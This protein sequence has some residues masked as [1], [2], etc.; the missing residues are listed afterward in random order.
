MCFLILKHCMDDEYLVAEPR[1][2]NFHAEYSHHL[3]IDYVFSN[4][5][6]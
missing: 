4:L 2:E 1:P 3:Q 5:Y 6:I